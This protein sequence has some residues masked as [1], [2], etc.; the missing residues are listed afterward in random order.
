MAV[1]QENVELVQAIYTRFRAGD[2]DSALELVHPEMELH[3][4]PEIPDPQV[5]HGHQGV[6]DSL[7]VSQVTFEGLEL[8]P[9]EFVDAGDQVVVVFRFT[10]TGR[11]SRIPVDE[12]LAHR[13]TIRDGKAT[14]MDVH[15]NREDALRAAAL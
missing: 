3:D 13:W 7:R 4:R 11:E 5:Y 2:T 15:S 8:T 10:G 12:R 6:L 14:R 9:E 1:S